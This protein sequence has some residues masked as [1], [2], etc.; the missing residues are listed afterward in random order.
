MKMFL[1]WCSNNLLNAVIFGQM[2]TEMVRHCL[3]PMHCCDGH[4]ADINTHSIECTALS[5]LS[6]HSWPVKFACVEKSIARKLTN[7]SMSPHLTRTLDEMCRLQRVKTKRN[8]QTNKPR[9]QQYHFPV[10]P[11]DI[12]GC[13]L[14]AAV[15]SFAYADCTATDQN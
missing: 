14:L 11:F 2:T 1:E 6:A 8:K 7:R 13:W 12:A 3:D 9:T 5:P 4:V 15:L 10:H